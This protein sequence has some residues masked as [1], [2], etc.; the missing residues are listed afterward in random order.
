MEAIVVK[1]N[2]VILDDKYP[3][4]KPGKGEV[5]IEVALAGICSTDL[6]IVK[7]YMGFSGV[8]GHEFVGHVV[9]GARQW[10]GKR[11]V[12][13]INNVCS[14]CDMCLSGLSNH[15]RNR[16]VLGIAGHDGVFAKY[17]ILPV[18]NLYEVP[19][20][21]TNEQAVFV[22]PVAAVLQ[23]TQQIRI[24]PH[25]KV[26]V[27][28]D[29]RLGL[30]AVQVLAAAGTASNIMLVGKHEEKL[31]FCEKRGLQCRHLDDM[32]LKPQWDI[33]VDCTGSTSGFETAVKLLRPRGTLVL[34]STFMADAPIDLS[35]LVINEITL[36]G[37]RCGPFQ[38]AIN[39]IAAERV[40]VNG[41]ITAQYKLADGVE[42]LAKAKA[43]NQIKVTLAP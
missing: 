17:V 7:G 8:L 1:D 32:V 21:L 29:G 22:E 28:G 14:K 26:A 41:L 15:C 18:H 25:Y 36:V 5:L 43:P 9:K 20:I 11:V 12:G 3:K 42:A 40:V 39:E 23:I 24:E 16:T 6:E 37:S 2:N 31:S 27:I 38:E 13:S 34:K 4:P 30:L 19:D 33:V 10:I 35:L